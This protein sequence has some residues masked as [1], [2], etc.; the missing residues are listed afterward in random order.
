MRLWSWLGS[1]FSPSRPAMMARPGLNGATVRLHWNASQLDV[2]LENDS[3]EAHDAVAYWNGLMG[4][5]FFAPP[6]EAPLH[7]L[8]AFAN[9]KLRAGMEGAVLVRLDASDSDHGST[10]EEYDK[11][12][13]RM[14]SAIV[15]LPGRSRRLADVVKH[16]FGHVL[17]LDHS[18]DGTL[19]GPHLP[20][21][22]YPTPLAGYQLAAVRA[23]G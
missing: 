13:G 18:D 16:E 10:L 3:P 20:P 1:L 22:G 5:R 23:I 14:I 19:M 6:M 4:R 17:G 9:P 15:T 7:I 11:R 2:Y 21:P 12:T 8:Q